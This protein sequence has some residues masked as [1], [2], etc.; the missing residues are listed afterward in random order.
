MPFGSMDSLHLWHHNYSTIQASG[1]PGIEAGWH[2]LT[3][4]P[5]PYD[6]LV[7]L[8]LLQRLTLTYNIRTS[9]FV[10]A[11]IPLSVCRHHKTPY[12]IFQ[13]F[14]FQALDQS[15]KLFILSYDSMYILCLGHF[16]L[17]TVNGMVHAWRLPTVGISSQRPLRTNLK[18]GCHAANCPF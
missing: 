6:F 13:S 2:L 16:C 17:H 3:E 8:S 1:W 4:L 15:T 11:L 14:S 9:C 10:P 7:S 5:C 18:N 12:L